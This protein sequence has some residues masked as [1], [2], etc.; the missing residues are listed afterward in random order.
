VVWKGAYTQ[1]L[2]EKRELALHNA[3]NPELDSE[4]LGYLAEAQGESAATARTGGHLLPLHPLIELSPAC[5]KPWQYGHLAVGYFGNSRLP[6]SK[7]YD[8]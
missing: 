3:C 6:G 7:T 1:W 5:C 4:R 2:L 8:S